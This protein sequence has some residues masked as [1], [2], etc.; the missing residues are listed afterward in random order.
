MRW[1]CYIVNGSIF[2]PHFLDENLDQVFG[3]AHMTKMDFNG[4]DTVTTLPPDKCLQNQGVWCPCPAPKSSCGTWTVNT[5]TQVNP[6][7]PAMDQ[8]SRSDNIFTIAVFIG[9]L[10]I[11]HHHQY[12][13]IR[14]SFSKTTRRYCPR[15][16]STSSSPWSTLR[17]WSPSSR[18]IQFFSNPRQKPDVFRAA[19]A[20]QSFAWAVISTQSSWLKISCGRQVS[21]CETF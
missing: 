11:H 8:H 7:W 14:I 5:S 13:V 12:I 4:L 3:G 10:Y 2:S 21:L 1:P 17:S 6:T 19:M 18:Y 20:G 15:T 9:I 16:A